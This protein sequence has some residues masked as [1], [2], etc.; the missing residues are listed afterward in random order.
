MKYVAILIEG[1]N[2]NSLGG[3]CQRDIWNMSNKLVRDLPI[4]VKY[5]YTFFHNLDDS[6]VS[7]I[8]RSGIVNNSLNSL[9]NVRK[10]FE[11]I[12]EWSK[13]EQL[14]IYFHYSGHGYQTH[15]DNG[16]EVDGMDE[17][18][19]G[20]TMKDDFIWNELVV[21]LSKQTHIFLTIDAC[22]SG[23]GADLPYIWNDSKSKWIL[24]KKKNV[25]AECSGFSLSACNDS[26]LSQQ[27]VGETIGFSGSLT[28]GICDL[29]NFLQFIFEPLNLYHKLVPRLL[30]LRQ[31]IDLY[32]VVK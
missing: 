6:Y 13:K 11:N 3:A 20:H 27:D 12:V 17:I 7:K 28:A 30:M 29:G 9:E 2:E 4:D 25:R 14:V 31:S 10:C 21:K 18:F 15:D 16:D 8:K 1:D 23:S 5:I 22:H 24:S 32:S 26:Q 19:M